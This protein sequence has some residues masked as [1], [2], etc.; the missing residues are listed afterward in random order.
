[1]KL[2]VLALYT[3]LAVCVSIVVGAV[4]EFRSKM[5]EVETFEFGDGLEDEDL[6]GLEEKSIDCSCGRAD[7]SYIKYGGNAK[8][9]I[10]DLLDKRDTRRVEPFPTSEEPVDYT[11][12]Y[13]ALDNLNLDYSLYEEPAANYYNDDLWSTPEYEYDNQ[14][15]TRQDDGLDGL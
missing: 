2:R 6:D 14:Q 15:D 1:M 7:C 12:S 4:T 8:E 11:A 9:W 10:K 3:V 13:E 5:K